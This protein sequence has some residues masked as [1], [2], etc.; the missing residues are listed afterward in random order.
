MYSIEINRSTG[1]HNLVFAH[2]SRVQASC[3]YTNPTSLLTMKLPI[4]FLFVS[5][6]TCHSVIGQEAYEIRMS[7]IPQFPSSY[8]PFNPP[9]W[10]MTF[11]EEFSAGVW[12]WIHG[13]TEF[14]IRDH[15]FTLESFAMS[16]QPYQRHLEI[17]DAAKDD[18]ELRALTARPSDCK[19]CQYLGCFARCS[20]RFCWF[21]A[22]DDDNRRRLLLASS[23]I[24]PSDLESSRKRHLQFNNTEFDLLGTKISVIVRLANTC[25]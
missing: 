6:L 1:L 5:L 2:S 17:L 3:L 8:D 14:A 4:L 25:S 9:T 19:T 22:N 24:S 11:V 23:N 10:N 16:D 12:D 21:Y 15:D 7:T 13:L 20:P 18:K